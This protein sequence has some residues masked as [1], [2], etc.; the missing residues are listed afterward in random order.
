MGIAGH[1]TKE[2]KGLSSSRGNVVFSDLSVPQ[3]RKLNA[4]LCR[5]HRSQL[6][7]QRPGRWYAPCAPYQ[8]TG[9]AVGHSR[10]GRAARIQG[11]TRFSGTAEDG[12]GRPSSN[13]G[14]SATALNADAAVKPTRSE[15]VSPPEPPPA[16]LAAPLPRLALSFTPPG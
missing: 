14:P 7:G 16:P 11:C 10:P 4:F 9:Y 1:C 8:R 2:R 12:D 13:S 6:P 15:P 3:G 5:C